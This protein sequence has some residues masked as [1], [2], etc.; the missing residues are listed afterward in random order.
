M[1]YWSQEALAVG[2]LWLDVDRRFS[3]AYHAEWL[4]HPHAF[5]I[6]L[7]LPLQETV[8]APDQARPFFVNLLP[9]GGVR[10]AVAKKHGL[11]E[12]NDFALLQAIGGECAGALMLL[13]EH[14]PFVA[15]PGYRA[16]PDHELDSMLAQLPTY[17]LLACASNVRLS[18]AGAQDKLPVYIHDQRIHLPTGTSPTSH[19]IKPPIPHFDSTVINEGFCMTLAKR[20]ALTVPDIEVWSR[21]TQLLIVE[22][23]DRTQVQQQIRRIHQE[24]LC[25][26]LG[27]LPE[28]KYEHEGGPSIA[29]CFDM[30]ERHSSNPLRD[31]QQLLRWCIFNV[32][33]GNM[34]AHAKNLSL[35]IE[36][37]G[38]RLAPFY[39]LLATIVYPGLSEK[40]A[41]KIGG[42]NRIPWLQRRHWE[43]FA[44]AVGIQP[45][46]VREE[47]GAMCLALPPLAQQL[48]H[49]WAHLSETAILPVIVDSITTQCQRGK[50]WVD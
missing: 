4:T 9:E 28:E 14:E 25:Q 5:P 45:R 44:K 23:Y 39:D 38:V 35:V 48:A 18:L 33:I 8:F 32:L 19:I 37:E 26:A 29:R 42:E 50:A 10:T 22:R 2:Q 1:V 12:R 16:L 24:D 6:S 46:T 13:P 7:S 41:M 31:R 21:S 17:P 34:D 15:N 49:A 36:P 40:L 3:F 30:V 11:S 27:I 43:R 20:I 47:I